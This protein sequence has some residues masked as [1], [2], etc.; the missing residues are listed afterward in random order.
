LHQQF[1]LGV[2]R[3]GIHLVYAHLGQ[4]CTALCCFGFQLSGSFLALRQKHK[5]LGQ[6]IN[7]RDHSGRQ[8]QQCE[9]ALDEPRV[10]STGIAHKSG[11]HQRR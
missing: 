7:T 1:F 8:Q 2:L 11:Q 9:V 6:P 4:I 3:I 10:P 5:T